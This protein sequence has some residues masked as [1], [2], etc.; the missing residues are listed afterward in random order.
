[1]LLA[2]WKCTVR[3]CALVWNV[4][5]VRRF[6]ILPKQMGNNGRKHHHQFYN[7]IFG[8]LNCKSTIYS[9]AYRLKCKTGIEIK[10]WDCM[11][12]LVLYEKPELITRESERAKRGGQK[13]NNKKRIFPL[14]SHKLCTPTEHLWIKFFENSLHTVPWDT[15][16]ID[17]ILYV[18]YRQTYTLMWNVCNISSSLFFS[19]YQCVHAPQPPPPNEWLKSNY[20]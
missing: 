5:D 11:A 20:F 3:L 19:F 4:R 2:Q 6:C 18:M 9:R 15:R 10:H 17:S 1:M 8:L 14:K 16:I 7:I 12:K 13:S